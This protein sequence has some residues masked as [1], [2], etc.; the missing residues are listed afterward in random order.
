MKKYMIYA[1]AACMTLVG[2]GCSKD[3]EESGAEQRPVAEGKYRLPSLS[4]SLD[5]DAATRTSGPDATTGAVNWSAKDRILIVRIPKTDTDPWATWQY[6]LV[7]GASSSIGEFEPIIGGT[8][9]SSNEADFSDLIAVYPVE[10]AYVENGK[11]SFKINQNWYPEDEAAAAA[12]KERLEGMGIKAWTKD[13]QFAFKRNDIKVSYKCT[14]TATDKNVKSANFK[15]RQLGAWCKFEFDFTNTTEVDYTGESLQRI[16]VSTVDGTTKFTGTADVDL[17][18]R[19]NPTLTSSGDG[20]SIDWTFNSGSSM[21]NPFTRSM[22]LYPGELTNQRLKIVAETNLHTFTFYATPKQALK[23]GTVFH[24]P[25]SL[26]FQ[27]F[28]ENDVDAA[29]SKDLAYT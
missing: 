6:E 11:L 18:D 13:D 21:G 17:S 12:W 28:G 15:F 7:K 3:F 10:A 22:M 19:N 8:E 24:F 27:S 9:A 5:D 14:P 26:Q 29:A 16:A 20:T 2:A 23:A 25:I 4:A 1:F